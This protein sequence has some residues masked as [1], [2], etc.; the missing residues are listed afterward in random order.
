MTEGCQSI[1]D[2][3]I[4]SSSTALEGIN[5]AFLVMAYEQYKIVNGI[6]KAFT[7]AWHA[8]TYNIEQLHVLMGPVPLTRSQESLTAKN[9]CVSLLELTCWSGRE[10]FTYAKFGHLIR[11]AGIPEL[12]LIPIPLW[13]D[14]YK[15]IRVR[16]I[17]DRDAFLAQIQSKFGL[18]FDRLNMSYMDTR[19]RI[20]NKVIDKRKK[21]NILS[22]PDDIW[23]KNVMEK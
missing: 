18:L 16:V 6:L 4:V 15:E 1:F 17:I 19:T 21:E 14:H 9:I 13:K 5:G 23:R 11:D 7:K 20:Y 12:M 22:Y 3:W 2:T 10:A 8:K